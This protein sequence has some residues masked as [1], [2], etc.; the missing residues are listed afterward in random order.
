M[1]NQE[2]IT[3]N[4]WKDP[5]KR[6]KCVNIYPNG[7][8]TPQKADTWNLLNPSILSEEGKKIVS[9]DPDL[10][11]KTIRK[12]LDLGMDESDGINLFLEPEDGSEKLAG[13][14]MAL[15]STCIKDNP[16]A[17]WA[18]FTAR[19]AA[20]YRFP[21]LATALALQRYMEEHE[22]FIMYKSSS[23]IPVQ[24]QPRRA[25]IEKSDFSREAKIEEYWD[26][27]A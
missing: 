7:V 3:G 8:P 9:E 13:I 16:Y 19:V 18:E 27:I 6:V 15:I 21:F 26:E 2:Q 1:E 23:H 10:G 22:G 5:Y 11:E 4:S 20:T 14:G 24:W 17:T 12:L 25:H